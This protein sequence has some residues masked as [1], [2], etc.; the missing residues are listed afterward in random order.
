MS[1]G[2]DRA[3]AKPPRWCVVGLGNPGAQYEGTRHNVGFDVV[4]H[5]AARSNVSIR[6]REFLALTAVLE[7]RRTEVLIMQPQTFMNRSG[8]AVCS[9]RRQLDLDI[10]RILVVYDDVDLELG[11]L[12][13]RAGG[14][15]GGHR[16]VA[17]I[18]DHLG[19]FEFPR[20]RLGI[21]RP[22]AGCDMV[23][24]VLGRFPDHESSTAERMLT[25][26]VDAV[27]AVVGDGLKSAMDRFHQPPTASD[28]SASGADHP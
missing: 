24:H 14:G 10:E 7:I 17:S 25:M 19:D 28:T 4:A 22:A 9:A 3:P 1:A 18:I 20:L 6:R 15:S 5:L 26:A 12:R 11:R 8:E 23:E 2:A 13:L 16:G 21:G 27:E